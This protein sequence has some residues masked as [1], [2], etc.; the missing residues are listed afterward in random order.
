MTALTEWMKKLPPL[1]WLAA[2]V[3]ALTL[4]R[5]I[6]LVTT[7]LNLGPDEAQYWSWSLTPAF[8][9]FS[10]P[11]MIAWIIGLT[12]GVCGDGEACIRA[13]A[14]LMHAITAFLIFFAGKALYDERVGL[15]SGVAYTL[16]PGTSFSSLLITTDVP[17]LMFWTLALWALAELRKA[18]NM[19]WAIVFGAAIGFGLL[20][21]YAMLYFVLGLGLAFLP[22]TNGR[23]LLLS[24]AGA[25]AALAALTVFAPNVVWNALHSFA[26]VGHTAANANWSVAKLFN[27]TNTLSFIAAQFGIAGPIAG[28]LLAWGLIRNWRDPRYDSS[29][30]LL[31]ALTLPIF[32]IVTLQAF[33]S[34]ANANWAAPAFVALT[35]LFT[36]WAMRRS[37]TFVLKA[38][39]CLNAAIALILGAL[40]MSP[41]FVAAIGQENSVKRLRGWDEAGR[42][43]VSV[44]NSGAYDAIMSDDREDMASLFYYTRV[45]ELPLRMWPSETARNEY[46]V[47]HRLRVD[48]AANVLFVTRQSDVRAITNA[49]ASS[50]R[51]GTLETRLDSKRKRV[52]FLFTLK[53]PVDSTL[54]P[55]YFDRPSTDN[56]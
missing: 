8:G 28:G 39:A 34:R 3:A 52:F 35:I 42:T 41:A 2:L 48:E 15:W 32:A 10:K 27:I 21:K 44:A 29:D 19:E 50:Q 6:V 11:P 7:P 24:R 37:N 4:F 23:S 20:S 51:I 22:T 17:L 36:A 56:R 12:T 49:F 25:I 30:T 47:S 13:G 38:N 33:V 9:Y 5:L 46:E 1:A 40:A 55:K 14:P 16:M 18:A 54:F 31:L 43:I 45:R 26:T 53:G